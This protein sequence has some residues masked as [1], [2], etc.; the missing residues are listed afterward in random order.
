MKKKQTSAIFIGIKKNPSL[1]IDWDTLTINSSHDSRMG[2]KDV[3]YYDKNR[4]RQIRA[5]IWNFDLDAWFLI[6]NCVIKDSQQDGECI[7]IKW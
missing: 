5:E 1:N 3:C 6:S 4:Q 2:L 7:S